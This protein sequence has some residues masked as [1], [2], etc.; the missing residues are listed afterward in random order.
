MAK[1][2]SEEKIISMS[3]L[4][5]NPSK[6]LSAKIVRIVKNGKEIGIFMSKQQFEDL[7]EDFLPFTEEFE[8]ELKESEEETRNGNY[9]PLKLD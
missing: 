8:K 1:L 4:Q 3:E 7:I 9:T 5:K 2:L 6:A